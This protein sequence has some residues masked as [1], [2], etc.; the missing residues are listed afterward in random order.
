[1]DQALQINVYRGPRRLMVATT[2][3]GLEP[4]NI[5]IAVSGHQLSVQGRLRGLGQEKR[6]GYFQHEWSVGPYNR[7]VDLPLAVDATRANASYDN[8]VLVMIFPLAAQPISGTMTLSKVGTAKGQC[9]R[10]VG[11]DLRD[12]PFLSNS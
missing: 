12:A 11:Q 5:H 10:H 1:M 9:I 6:P 7:T 8:G 2:V 4:Q 3:P